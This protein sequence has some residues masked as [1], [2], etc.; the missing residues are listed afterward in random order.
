MPT[1]VLQNLYH[2]YGS[3][4][5]IDN[6]NWNQTESEKICLVGRNGEGKSTLMRI[7]AGTESP[8]QGSVG[9]SD[10][11]RIG[12]VP[13]ELPL[14]DETLVR[15]FILSGA[16][17][18][19]EYILRYEKLLMSTPD[20]PDVE[21]VQH[22]IEEN[23]AW[24]LM[25]TIEAVL[26]RFNLDGSATMSQLSGG[27]RRK[28]LIA[29]AA[30]QEP[31]V[32]LLDEPTNHLDV[33]SIRWL[34]TW[35]KEF[36][37]LV[38][39]ISHDRSFIDA[40]AEVIVEL[41]RSQLYRYPI[42][43]ENFVD[44][45]EERLGIEAEQNALFDKRLAQEEAWIRQGVKARRTRNEGRVRRL[46]ALRQER[47]QR[48]NLGGK[49][50]IQVQAA[51]RSGKLVFDLENLTFHYPGQRIVEN[52][53]TEIMRGETVALVGA[54]GIGKTTLIKLLLGQI[55]PQSGS[56]ITGTNLN[57]AYFDQGRH[58]L[59][60]EKTVMDTVSEGRDFIEIN[61]KKVHVITYLERFLFSPKRA[62]SPVKSLSGGEANRLL[63]ARLF[64]QPANMLVLDE[65][66]NDLD[67]DT[68]ELLEE[69]IADFPGTVILISHDRYFVDNVATKVWG[70]PGNGQVIPIV[71]G[72]REW[73]EFWSK[74]EAMAAGDKKAKAKTAPADSNAGVT[75]KPK[76]LSYKDQRELDQLPDKMAALE[77]EI[78]EL[79]DTVAQPTFYTQEQPAVQATLNLL[80]EKEAS[81]EALLE[82]WV[83]LGSH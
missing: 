79:H 52:L 76:K 9:W 5:V 42:P 58:Q 19:A 45:R 8:D 68:L 33:E 54:N 41:D 82:R 15:D 71:G 11:A 63:L 51:E 74:Q 43:Y 17:K 69:L 55:Q 7:L 18:A 4:P 66:T 70:M 67:I 27:W 29:R 35:L 32:L 49:A 57:V 75:Q 36:R 48:R 10:D 37:G 21:K 77:Q 3:E 26:Q 59:D 25:A 38:I 39:F 80:A 13:Q 14:P 6:L 50:D 56:L 34:E 60:P 83:E 20:H 24:P 62:R 81:L 53:T 12:Y 30:I 23:N 46:E 73:F 78:A 44:N 72:Y 47:S 65:P 31:N 22:W 16:G 2:A 40:V 64:S 28:A 61:N 1:L